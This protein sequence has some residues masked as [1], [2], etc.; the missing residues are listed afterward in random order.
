M[1]TAR[2]YQDIDGNDCTIWQMVRR[3]PEWAASRIQVG[4][5]A[6]EKITQAIALIEQ[7]GQTDGSHHKAWVLD[8]VA[9]VLV[10]NYEKWVIYMKDG[11]DGPDTYGYDEGIAPLKILECYQ[12]KNY[13]IIST[14]AI[15]GGQ[16]Q[17]GRHST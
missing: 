2:V 3:E 5:N 4:E 15:K 13:H 14:S 10:D 16:R 1:N 12:V 9:R 8:Q 17:K 6:E 7:Y 11:E